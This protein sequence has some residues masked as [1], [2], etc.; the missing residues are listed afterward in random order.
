MRHSNIRTAALFLCS[1]TL[2]A[3]SVGCGTSSALQQNPTTPPPQSLLVA[4]WFNRRVL[5][6]NS[7]FSSGQSAAAV[8]GQPDFTTS[9]QNVSSSTL[10]FCEKAI[11]DSSGNIWVSDTWNH[12][13]LEFVKPISSG[14]VA[15]VVLGQTDFTT[16][17][18]TAPTQ[19]S[20]MDPL[21]IAL[22]KSGNLWV[23]DGNKR[24]LEFK[25]PFTNGMNASVVLGQPNFTSS[26]SLSTAAGL[27]F[28][29]EL[30]FDASGNLW[31]VD[32][33][34]NRVLEYEPPFVSGQSARVVL[35]QADF[36]SAVTAT[37]ASGLNSPHGIALDSGGNVWVADTNNFRILKF[38]PPFAN[39]MNASMVLGQSNF[40]SAAI[41]GDP[42]VGVSAP[43]GIAFDSIGSLFVAEQ[44]VNRVVLFTPPFSSMM[45][46]SAVLGQPDFNSW[47]PATTASVTSG[48]GGVSAY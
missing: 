14:M 33:G 20:L 42:Q 45:K 24:I 46:A 8:L 19:S 32:Q 7:P 48:P 29:T 6:F 37:T 40:T 17:N 12:R 11:A 30:S 2:L 10:G 15:S 16:A 36:T 38:S 22:D 47:H 9:N 39:G 13:V 34:N 41:A 28:P 31:V 23:A 18:A 3:V 27:S 44:S 5:I 43:F 21:G 25:P 35:G 26:A 4:D 1:L